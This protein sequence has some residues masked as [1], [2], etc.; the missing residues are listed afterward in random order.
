MRPQREHQH[1]QIEVV[2]PDDFE[3]EEN[4]MD[5]PIY[6]FIEG[7][8]ALETFTNLSSDT[9][10]DIWHVV[11]MHMRRYRHRGPIPKTSTLD[12]LILYLM[13]MKSAQPYSQI[14][15]VFDINETLVEDAL[16]RVRVP[17]LERHW[18][19]GGG[20][21]EY[22]PNSTMALWH[23]LLLSSLMATLPKLDNQNCHTMKQRCI[24]MERTGFMATNLKLPFPPLLLITAS[25]PPLTTLDRHMTTKS[26]RKSSEPTLS[27]FK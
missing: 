5:S 24:S 26:T 8:D 12:H 7:N 27:T 10:E 16:N 25:L 11:D 3:E 22:D 2:I 9:I 20:H 4:P 23:L 18:K 15:A 6:A 14:A 19:V 21:P 17:L 1:R 13:W